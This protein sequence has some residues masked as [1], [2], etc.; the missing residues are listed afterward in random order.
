MVRQ[1][2]PNEFIENNQNNLKDLTGITYLLEFNYMSLYP[3]ICEQ[4]FGKHKVHILGK[5]IMVTFFGE[6]LFTFSARPY[7]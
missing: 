2:D 4:K 5:I 7:K 1:Q 6:L 3:G